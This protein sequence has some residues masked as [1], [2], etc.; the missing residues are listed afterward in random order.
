MFTR[1]STRRLSAG[2]VYKLWLVGLGSS[3][4]PLGIL[5][6]IFALFGFNTIRWNG[7]VLHGFAGLAVGPLLGLLLTVLFTVILGSAAALGLWLYSKFRPISL[8]AKEMTPLEGR[9]S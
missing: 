1:I 4:I 9:S 6:G 8:L 7:H 2:S 5:Y 3:M